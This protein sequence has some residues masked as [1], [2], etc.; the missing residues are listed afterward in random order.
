[1]PLFYRHFFRYCTFL[2]NV[3]KY[4]N[5]V[6][7]K[8]FVKN[9]SKIRSDFVIPFFKSNFK[10]YSFAVISCNLLNTFISSCI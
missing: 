7:Y 10:K 3:C 9:N 1:M 4:D 5:C 6:L 2:F 8:Y